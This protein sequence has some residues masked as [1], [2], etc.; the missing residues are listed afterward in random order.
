MRWRG[1]GREHT[2]VWD[3]QIVDSSSDDDDTLPMT[4]LGYVETIKKTCMI[5]DKCT[6]ENERTENERNSNN[7]LRL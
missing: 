2:V 4:L 3:G 7:F 1:R 6:V 5:I